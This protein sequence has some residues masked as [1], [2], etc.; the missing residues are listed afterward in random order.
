MKIYAE[1]EIKSKLCIALKKLYVK[2]WFLLEKSVHERSITHKLA[3]YLQELFPDYDVDCEYNNDIDS[4]KK[5]ISNNAMDKLK[6]ELEKIKIDSNA[7]D[8]LAEIKKLSKNFYPDIIIHK[9]N[10][11]KHN[12]LIIEAKK[13]NRDTSFDEEKLKAMT[14]KDKNSRYKYRLGALVILDVAD[15][16]KGDSIALPRYFQNGVEIK[17]DNELKTTRK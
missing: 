6:L 16:F 5:F 17:N 12:L 4:R 11:N 7:S 9:R 1:E 15:N 14:A 13:E 2:D 8:L 3:E 10:S